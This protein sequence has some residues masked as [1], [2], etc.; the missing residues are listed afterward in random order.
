[1]S[2]QLE[3]RPVETT[4]RRD[5]AAKLWGVHT[6][7]HGL[8]IDVTVGVT[9]FLLTTIGDL[10]WTRVYWLALGLGVARTTVQAVIAY[11]AR[12]LLPPRQN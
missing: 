7:M 2:H 10:E 5:W 9:L 11:A 4:A 12:R 6:V 3:R 8:A 1:V